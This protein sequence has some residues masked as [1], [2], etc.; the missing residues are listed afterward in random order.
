MSK[1]IRQTLF[2]QK[3][4]LHLPEAT[5]KRLRQ[6]LAEGA[7]HEV[8]QAL[9]K[10]L[11]CDG[12]SDALLRPLVR[13]CVVCVFY[14]IMQKTGSGFGTT[15]ASGS[16]NLSPLALCK[17][18]AARLGKTSPSRLRDPLNMKGRNLPE[19]P[20]ARLGGCEYSPRLPRLFCVLASGQSSK[21]SGSLRLPFG[22]LGFTSGSS[23]RPHSDKKNPP[24]FLSRNNIVL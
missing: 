13:V 14:Q 16:S 6:Q 19:I 11:A 12:E 23:K 7:R 17:T 5:L 1:C 3:L 8:T 10:P 18:S 21:P 9:S 20:A 15:S 22:F 4:H 24:R 2:S